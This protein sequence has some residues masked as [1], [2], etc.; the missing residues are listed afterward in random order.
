MLRWSFQWPN[1][2]DAHCGKWVAFLVLVISCSIFGCR[3]QA[4]PVGGSNEI[5]QT[6]ITE[7]GLRVD[8][9]IESEDLLLDLTP[10]LN[11][12]ALWFQENSAGLKDELPKDLKSCDSVVGIADKDPAELFHAD[13]SE[14]SFLEVIHWPMG[15]STDTSNESL[16]ICETVECRLGDTEVWRG[17]RRF[18]ERSP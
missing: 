18:Y 3:K 1:R 5:G 10:R 16:A 11:A 13:P 2:A 15:E 8:N 17:C 4:S 12:L 14:P 6:G 7:E 9:L